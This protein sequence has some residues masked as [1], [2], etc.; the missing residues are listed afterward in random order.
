MKESDQRI[1]EEAG[2]LLEY[3][4]SFLE[5]MTPK[6]R[7]FVEDMIEELDRPEPSLTFKQYNWICDLADKY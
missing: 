7:D 1:L 5:E 4:E 3:L 6:E 2:H